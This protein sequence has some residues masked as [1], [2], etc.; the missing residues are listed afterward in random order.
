MGKCLIIGCGGVAS[1]AIHKC[2]QNS[3][4]FE[5]ILI[6]SRTISKCEALKAKLSG[7]NTKI[8]T[9][10]VNADHVDELIALIRDFQPDVVLNLALPYQDLT[11]MDACLATKT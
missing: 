1:V 3:N 2:C 7:G 11:I 10:Q 5:E 4:V 6:A 9:A 8:R